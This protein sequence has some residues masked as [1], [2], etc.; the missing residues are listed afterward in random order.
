MKRINV[1]ID[2]YAGCGKSTLARDLAKALGYVFVDSGA[3]YRGITL[4][5]VQRNVDVDDHGAVLHAL[6]AAPELKFGTENN[7]LLLDGVDVEADI[8]S[9]QRVLNLV[10]DAAAI[11]EVRK[12]L[13]GLQEDFVAKKGVVME[14]RDIGTVIMPAAELKLF[15]T[16]SIEERIRR[17]SNDLSHRG[18]GVKDSEIRKNLEERDRKD[19]ERE[20]AP[21][22]MATDAIAVDS[23]QLD[24]QEQLDLALALVRPL[25]S[26]DTLLPF[27]Q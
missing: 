24:R 21:L 22:R 23:T 5:L 10:S 2:G 18:E 19:A 12:F 17:R 11:P 3:L 16:A 15:I 25:I 27:I 13:N 8:R 1:A 14:G 4:Y 7:H 20:Q 9:D 26:P 6:K